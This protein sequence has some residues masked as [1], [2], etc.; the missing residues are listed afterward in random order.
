[1]LR[2][3]SRGGPCIRLISRCFGCRIAFRRYYRLIIAGR[4]MWVFLLALLVYQ[5]RLLHQDLPLWEVAIKTLL[6]FLMVYN[7]AQNARGTLGFAVELLPIGF[8]LLLTSSVFHRSKI[9]M[10]IGIVICLLSRYAFTFWLPLYLLIYWIEYGFQPVLRVSLY[11]L[12]G[13]LLLYVFPFLLRDTTILTEGLKYYGKTA[14]GQWQTQYWQEEG[15]V[16]HHLNKGLSLAMYFYDD[17]ELTVPDRLQR[18]RKV[19]I[20]ACAFAA[21]LL[22]LG[23]FLFRRRGLNVKLYLI[24]G[25]KFYLVIFYGFFYVPFSYLY[26]LPLF[27]SLALIYHI[28]LSG[29]FNPRREIN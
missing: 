26:Q 3:N 18:N 27:L 15:A 11:T 8:Y 16:P 22:A 2:W 25:L 12:A 13:V 29:N 14:E 1:M 28:N 23:Y 24:I 19:H 4:P 17:V 5:R 7:F 21:L 9:V 10:A 20:T 6:P